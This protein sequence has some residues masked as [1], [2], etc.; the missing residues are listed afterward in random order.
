MRSKAG[1]QSKRYRPVPGMKTD[2]PAGIPF[3]FFSAKE[4]KKSWRISEFKK[5]ESSESFDNFD[6]FTIAPVFGLGSFFAHN[7]WIF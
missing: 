6:L 2:R 7:F 3:F 1:G 4:K 5:M